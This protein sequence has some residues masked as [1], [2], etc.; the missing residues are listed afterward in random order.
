MLEPNVDQFRIWLHVVAACVWIGGQ[1]ALAAFVPV[2]RRT[3][4]HDAL[5]AVARQF[6]RVAWPAFAVLVLT[7]MWNLVEIRIADQSGPYLGSVFLKL[8]LVALSGGGAAAHALATGPAVSAAADEANRHRKQ[9]VS[10][11]TAGFGLLF[12]LAAAFVGVQ[13]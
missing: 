4:D 3:A 10:G 13:L 6:Q 9:V 8:V 2:L 11:I 12:A 7:G 1:I 5:R